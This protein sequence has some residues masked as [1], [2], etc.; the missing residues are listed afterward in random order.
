MTTFSNTIQQPTTLV[1]NS[2]SF[3]MQQEMSAVCV[4][5]T[6]LQGA[7]TATLQFQN[8]IDLQWYDLLVN[9]IVPTFNSANNIINIAQYWGKF[10]VVK[11]ATISNV[12]VIVCGFYNYNQGNQS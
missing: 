7:E 9:S 2:S 11:T 10:R 8:P 6:G 5:C 3:V 12:G 1:S 4:I